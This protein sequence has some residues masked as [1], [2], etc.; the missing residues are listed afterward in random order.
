[1]TENSIEL[2]DVTRRAGPIPL[3]HSL[4]QVVRGKIQSGE[5]PVGSR[6]PAERA[7]M[8][9]YGVSRATVRQAIE[10]MVREGILHRAQGK[11]TF[12]APPKIKQGVLRLHSFTETMRRNGLLPRAQLLGKQNIDAPLNICKELSLGDGEQAI[13]LQRLILVNE[14]PVMIESSYLPAARFPGLLPVYDGAQDPQEFVAQH[15]D[16]RTVRASEVFEPVILETHEARLLGVKSG[17]PAL[18][19]E[20][21]SL[22]ANGSP[23]EFRASLLR[24]DR[25][26]FYIDLAFG[27]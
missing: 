15:F 19:V 27:E 3:Y 17:S 25:C 16:V 1:M 20:Q 23:V 12:V 21:I 6:I 24:G 5:W 18:W 11:G 4:G 2:G 8:Q 22:D 7:L 26:R 14:A 10:Y 13:W 9:I